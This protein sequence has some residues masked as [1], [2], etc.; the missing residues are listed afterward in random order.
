[1]HVSHDKQEMWL[2]VDIRVS[3]VMLK[4]SGNT[5]MV[6]LLKETRLNI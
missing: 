1:M 2:E 6:Y 5:D 3:Q 4:N